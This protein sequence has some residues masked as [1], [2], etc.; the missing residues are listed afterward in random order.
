MTDD[1]DEL[2]IDNFTYIYINELK[3]SSVLN[4]YYLGDL[5]GTIQY[6]KDPEEI[7][8]C[9]I[10]D[11]SNEHVLT[12]CEHSKENFE[13]VLTLSQINNRWKILLM[14][15]AE[16]GEEIWLKTALQNRDTGKISLLTS[17]N[18]KENITKRGSRTVKT[19]DGKW[20]VGH[21]RMSA[22]LIFWKELKNRILY[23]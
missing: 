18:K 3:K 9:I 19:I 14:M 10:P 20:Y 16:F 17:T 13:R 5:P 4:E 23:S 12:F 21:Y 7:I 11:E 8:N 22:P 15:K 1:N 2:I 6:K